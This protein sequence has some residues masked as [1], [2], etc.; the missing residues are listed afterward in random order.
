MGWDVGIGGTEV[1]GIKVLGTN[2]DAVD[3]EVDTDDDELVEP[4]A[5]ELAIWKHCKW[6]INWAECKWCSN[7]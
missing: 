6:P 3:T 2:A 4:A 7:S 1:S 5:G